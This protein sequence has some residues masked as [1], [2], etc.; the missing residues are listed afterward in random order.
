MRR[1]GLLGAAVLVLALLLGLVRMN[2]DIGEE[3]DA[4]MALA[5]VMGQLG[6]LG[7]GGV[8]G[9]PGADDAQ[10][11]AALREAQAAHPLR[12]LA[13]QVD[14]ADGRPLLAAP[15]AAPAAAPMRWLLALHR[16]WL[17]T[18]DA[19]RVAWTVARPDGSRWTV[20]LAAS[21]DSERREALGSLLGM[22]GL[23]LLGVT[24]L[25]AVMQWNLRH[26]LAPLGRLL[27]AIAGIEGRDASAVQALP[28]MPVTE[29]ESLAAALRHLGAALDDA[30]AQRR[31]LAQQVLTL[32][33]DERARLARELHDE[34]GQ[35][36]TALRVDAAWLSR[37]LAGDAALQPV[38]D[39][40]VQQCALVQQD[41][42]QLLARLQP[43]GPL[44]TDAAA[45][46]PAAESLGHG[47]ALLQAL[48]ASWRGSGRNLDCRLDL[49]W[50]GADGQPRPWPDEAGALA[51]RLPR[52]LWLTLYRISQ[53]ALTNV[54][55]HADAGAAGLAL[56]LHGGAAPGDG[57][58]LDWR[59]WDD[60]RGLA[61]A[62][63]A[64]PR[65]N[66]LA[67]LQ[68]RV[69]AQGAELQIAP[70]QPGAPRPGLCLR[71]SFHSRWLAL[72]DEGLFPRD[73]RN[74]SEAPTVHFDSSLP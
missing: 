48:V 44:A 61:D 23:L 28:A 49:A 18:A 64:R 6:Q 41:I 55:R 40:M 58:R 1:A 47:V 35:R 57:L 3:V 52:A 70:L 72:T 43:F 68:E 37:R 19:R 10:V 34:F 31:Q 24:G 26:A 46:V 63:A 27:Q 9:A 32:Q 62:A 56:H 16:D 51:L 73:N 50:T 8:A 42:R 2:Q 74:A 20:S 39:G 7:P 17:G 30:E 29:L 67:G 36:L 4:A 53:E 22:L 21:H 71:A 12:H 66:G 65:G 69:W 33:D 54:T 59:A 25:L 60:G 45:D 14:G 13:L 15:A 11:L 5:T 38:A